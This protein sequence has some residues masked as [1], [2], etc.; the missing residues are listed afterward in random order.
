M[1]STENGNNMVMPVSPMM[2]GYGG[3]GFGFGE[4]NGAWWIL[5]F[6]IFAAMGGNGW[7]GLGG[8]NM[9]PWMLNSNNTN[10]DVQR[11]FDQAAG[12]KDYVDAYLETDDGQ[13]FAVKMPKVSYDSMARGRS[14][15]TGRFVSRMGHP[16]EHYDRKYDGGYSGHSVN[17]K[18]IAALEHAMDEAETLYE[19]DQIQQEIHMLRQRQMK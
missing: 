12:M 10:N 5:L 15:V 7:G 3:N 16:M 14:P 18:M 1:I 4:G 13:S 17:D 8:G 9:M 19:R 6:F 2:G 11:G